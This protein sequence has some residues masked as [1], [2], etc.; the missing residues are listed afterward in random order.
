MSNVILRSK[1]DML[2]DSISAANLNI[3]RGTVVINDSDF[4]DEDAVVNH[5]EGA[6]AHLRE[7]VDLARASEPVIRPASELHAKDYTVTKKT[8]NYG[9]SSWPSK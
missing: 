4:I 1:I 2:N 5:L 8:Q 6:I 9:N 3:A 7:A